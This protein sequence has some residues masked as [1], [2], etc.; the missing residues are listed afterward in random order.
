M[1]CMRVHFHQESFKSMNFTTRKLRLKM[2]IVGIV[3]G[4][5]LN[6]SSSVLGGVYIHTIQ[7]HESESSVEPWYMRMTNAQI[8]VIK[9]IH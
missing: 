4:T 5:V 3:M 6:L 7:P 2:A 9:I 1:Q 8:T